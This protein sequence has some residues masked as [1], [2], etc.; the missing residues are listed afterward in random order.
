MD[1]GWPIPPPAPN[2]VTLN[3]FCVVVDM[4]RA[5]VVVVV[6]ESNRGLMAAV[7]RD[8]NIICVLRTGGETASGAWNELVSATVGVFHHQNLFGRLQKKHNDAEWRQ[9]TTRTLEIG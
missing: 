2:T 3:D 6:V 4:V 7:A 5:V 9:T 8:K 1:N